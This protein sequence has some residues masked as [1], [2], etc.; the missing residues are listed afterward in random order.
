MYWGDLSPKGAPSEREAKKQR[1]LR[2]K[3]I[4]NRYLEKIKKIIEEDLQDENVAI[5][6]YGSFA[7][8]TNHHASDIDI[9]II[10]KGK[11]KRAKLS[12]IREKLDELTIPYSVD[13]VD[14]SIVSDDFKKIALLNAK[15]WRK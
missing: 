9:A 4:M 6:L 2:L 3:K 14:F 1:S 15:W 10:P 7:A 12:S 11:L 8:G 5:A 13:L